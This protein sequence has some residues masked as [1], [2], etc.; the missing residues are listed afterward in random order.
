M[1]EM[2][3]YIQKTESDKCMLMQ[4]C[5]GQIAIPIKKSHEYLG[6]VFAYRDSPNLNLLHRLG[7]S[8]GQY[9]SLRRTI[10][11]RR[12]ISKTHRYRVWMAGYT[13]GL[14][15]NGK[16]QLQAMVSRQLRALA[17]L[18]AHT[19]H[20]TNSAI[21]EQFGFT[22]VVQQLCDQ[23][24]KHMASLE[25]TQAEKPGH[26]CVQDVAMQQL[27]E[28][29]RDLAP[30]ERCGQ[31]L[32]VGQGEAE[33]V[34]CPECGICFATLKGMRQHRAAKHKIKVARHIVFQP[35][36]H[37]L[38]GLP[39]C[40]GCNHKFQT[41][42]GL[43]KHIEQG[44]C[45]TPIPAAASAPMTGHG[46]RKQDECMQVTTSET[47]GIPLHS[48]AVQTVIREQGWEALVH[49][50]HA[51]TLKQHCCICGRWIVDPV[52]LKRHI[53]G[54]HKYTWEQHQHQLKHECSKLQHTLSRDKTCQYCG[55]TAQ[56]TIGT[57]ISAAS[58]SNPHFWGSAIM[59]QT[60]AA[61]TELNNIFGHLLPS[62]SA[63]AQ[64]QAMGKRTSSPTGGENKR[65]RRAGHRGPRKSAET[66]ELVSLM[67][68]IIISH[69]DQLGLG[70]LDRAFTLFMEQT[71]QVGVLTN[72]YQASLVWHQKR[73]EKQ[74]SHN[75]QPLRTTLLSLMM[76]ELV[77]RLNTLKDAKEDRMVC[78]K[79][80]WM[81]DQGNLTFQVWDPT[82][83][84]LVTSTTQE[85]LSV[86][87]IIKEMEDILGLI[88]PDHILKFHA[89]RPLRGMAEA[90]NKA[91]FNLEVTLR[92]PGAHQLYNLMLKLAGNSCWM[93][94]GAQVRRDSQRRSGAVQALQKLVYEGHGGQIWNSVHNND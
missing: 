70:R 45:R 21:R 7:K 82:K 61:T 10:H 9:A 29:I 94:I 74:P 48:A 60:T 86:Q 80:G 39:Q 16:T 50:E 78:Q 19:T 85:P 46:E 77:S 4:S 68:R 75:L 69:E 54:A 93:I 35:E 81:D 28:V 56:H 67:A 36:L 41:W 6:T 17:A 73:E 40:S 33:G 34:C 52:A 1:K 66:E 11:A 64:T 71:G 59:A 13:V 32:E 92:A 79:Q 20:V 88:N 27:R 23:A 51:E 24:T 65:H 57:T 49:R 84:A 53:K 30:K 8:R 89:Q 87:V 72:L 47:A 25:Q 62:L 31:L 76:M 44:S 14:S 5:Q 38:E 2:G 37:A 18:P 42:D 58:S 3:V 63:N 43:R 55:R 91:V 83:K 15:A 22:D 90:E 26:I 12:H